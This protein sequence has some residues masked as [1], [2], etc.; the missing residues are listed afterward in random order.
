MHFCMLV[1]GS[2]P[3]N[4]WM[5][6]IWLTQLLF[7]NAATLDKMAFYQTNMLMNIISKEE[8]HLPSSWKGTSKMITMKLMIK[9]ADF[10]KSSH[11]V[12]DRYLYDKTEQQFQ[13]RPRVLDPIY[14]LG[15][16]ILHG[17]V[18]DESQP[19]TKSLPKCLCSH[20]L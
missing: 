11:A 1:R 5:V 15:K 12:Q 17:I 13:I 2:F 10:K 8:H 16:H 4:T 9:I 18:D 20:Q 7:G 14:G 6:S 3:L 19:R